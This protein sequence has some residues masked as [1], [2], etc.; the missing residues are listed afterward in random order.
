MPTLTL[1]HTNDLHGHLTPPRLPA[2]LEARETA[3]LYFDSGD[4]VQSGNLAVPLRPEPVWPLLAQ[5]RC[6][7]SCPG[8]RESHPLAPAFHAKLAGHNHPVLCAN[9]ADKSGALPLPPSLVLHSQGLTVG[10]V[11]VM[12][13]IVTS[14]MAS[15]HASHFLWSPPIAAAV[16]EAEK[17]RPQVDLLVALTHI[18]FPQDCRLAETTT[19]FD[20]VLGG[21]SHTVLHQPERVNQTWICQTGSHARYIGRYTWAD[22]KLTSAELISWKNPA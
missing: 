5:A 13:P 12:V 21:H 14:N 3:D 18:G 1:L 15:R 6:D 9:L 2:L 10:V 16:A 7:A 4:A 11:A 20:L 17:L 8:N 19:L 22:G